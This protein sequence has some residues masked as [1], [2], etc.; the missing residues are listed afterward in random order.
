MGEISQKELD[1]FKDPERYQI[2]SFVGKS[3]VEQKKEGYLTGKDGGYQVEV[4]AVGYKINI[5]GQVDPIPG[6]DV[7]L[8]INAE[9][10]KISEESLGEKAGAIVAVDPR[11]GK[12]LVMASSPTFD[13]NLFSLGISARDWQELISN[14]EHPLMNRCIQGMHPP[15]STYKLVTAAAALEEGLVTKEAL[16]YCNGMHKLGNRTYRC[17]KRPGHGNV[18]LVK[19]MVE[20]CDVYFY[21]LGS[22]LGPDPLADYAKGF[23]FG[24]PTGISLQNE[25]G[26]LIPTSAWY[27]KK[28]RIPWQAGESL[29]IAIGQGSNLVTPLQLVMAYAAMANGGK[30]YTPYCIDRVVSV[31]GVVQEDN[32]PLSKRGIPLSKENSDLL[33]EC[34]WGVV[35]TP[36]GTGTLAAIPQRNVSGKTGTAQVVSLTKKKE[37]TD[38]DIYSDHAWFAAYAPGDEARIA[39]VVFVEH[40]GHGGSAAAPIA[41]AVI[42]RFFE[43]EEEGNV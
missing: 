33:K 36:T 7:I 43:L 14:P 37:N 39:V 35:N 28:Y 18:S 8:T 21:H 27:K 16:F 2:G 11:N 17:W 3:G 42:S 12:I 1:R 25:K 24:T 9:L 32:N 20:S 6:H 22:L 30:L 34:L 38:R 5:M 4:N 29:S 13:S 31:E 26:G 23:G 40:G 15:G 10:Q 41:H 19:A